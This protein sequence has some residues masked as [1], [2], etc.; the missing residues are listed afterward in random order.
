MRILG[1]PPQVGGEYCRHHRARQPGWTKLDARGCHDDGSPR[2]LTASTDDLAECD[3]GFVLSPASGF[4]EIGAPRL[5]CRWVR[6][7]PDEVLDGQP[8]NLPILPLG[9]FGPVTG[10]EEGP[11][12][13]TGETDSGRQGI[14]SPGGGVV[15]SREI[16]RQQHRDRADHLRGFFKIKGWNR[17]YSGQTGGFSIRSSLLTTIILSV[18]DPPT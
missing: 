11:G 8:D 15:G 13:E 5:S 10:R 17:W 16:S 14:G 18:S 2:D 4:R 6:L 1:K 12:D 9:S 3:I 7:V